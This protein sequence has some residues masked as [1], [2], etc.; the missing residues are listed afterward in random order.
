MKRPVILGAALAGSALAAAPASADIVKAPVGESSRL[1]VLAGVSRGLERQGITLSAAGSA[2]RARSTLVLPYSLARWDFAAREGDVAHFRRATGLRLRARGGRSIAMVHPRV[3]MDRRDAGYITALISNIRV[4]TFTFVRRGGDVTDTPERQR[5][6][7]LRLKLTKAAAELLNR[8]LRR[9]ALRPYTQF[10]T[11]ELRILKPGASAAP[12][13]GAPAPSRP[14]S[15]STSSPR[16]ATFALGQGAAGALPTGSTLAAIAP[17]TALDL[18]GDGQPD[19][20]VFGL[21]IAGTDLDATTRQGTVRLD[22]GFVV[23][24]NGQDVLRLDDPEVVLGATPQASGLFAL[25]D[26]VRVRVGEVDP[27]AVHLSAVDGTITVSD[28]DVR[29]SPEGAVILSGIPGVG[30]VLPGGSLALLDLTVPQV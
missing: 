19:T 7:G 5:I 8:G 12:G 25:V 17:A 27:A 23:R 9:R 26:G 18:N 2:T 6:T 14:G 16:S 21:G 10:G 24:A 3:V 15:G 29:I 22:G 4:K 30:D 28:L 20:G 11:L 13:A 1:T